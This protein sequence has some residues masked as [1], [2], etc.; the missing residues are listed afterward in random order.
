MHGYALPAGPGP[1]SC[2]GLACIRAAWLRVTC[3]RTLRAVLGRAGRHVRTSLRQR[4]PFGKERDLLK[5]QATYIA[6]DAMHHATGVMQQ[7]TPAANEPER[8]QSRASAEA[9]VPSHRTHPTRYP[10]HPRRCARFELPAGRCPL[11]LAVAAAGTPPSHHCSSS[12]FVPSFIGIRR[13]LPCR[14]GYRARS[15]ERNGCG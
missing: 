11:R 12:R 7:A 1:A 14:V 6:T 8:S 15:L 9:N 10:C 3:S 5:E 4:W 13:R 2:E